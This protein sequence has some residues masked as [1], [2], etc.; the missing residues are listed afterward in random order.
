VHPHFRTSALVLRLMF[1]L[2]GLLATLPCALSPS[3]QS[4]VF[5]SPFAALESRAE[6]G[7][8]FAQYNLAVEYLCSNPAAPDYRPAIKWLSAAAR[9]G[10]VQ[11]EFLLGYLY[12][13][14]REPSEIMPRP[15]RTTAITRRGQ[16]GPHGGIVQAA[17]AFPTRHGR[18]RAA[19]KPLIYQL[20]RCA[21]RLCS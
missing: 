3:E 17:T 2:P 1:I 11:A 5:A 14:G 15:P 9:Q 10:N 4:T 16:R 18:L 7:D 19:R 21:A 6:A 8:G 13:H 20:T 12:E